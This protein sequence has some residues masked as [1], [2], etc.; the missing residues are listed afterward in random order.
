[1]D[2]HREFAAEKRQLL[3]NMK[4]TDVARE[5]AL[6][7]AVTA[8]RMLGK[9]QVNYQQELLETQEQVSNTRTKFVV[10]DMRVR[11]LQQE[12]VAAKKHITLLQEKL[13]SSEAKREFAAT[14]GRGVMAGNTSLRDSLRGGT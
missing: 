7:R 1:M 13:A 2:L 3:K 11:K 4:V 5:E 6:D 9:N 14:N 8:E 12:A 10:M